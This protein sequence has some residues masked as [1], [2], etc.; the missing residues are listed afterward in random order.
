M[1][2]KKVI[3]GGN[4]ASWQGGVFCTPMSLAQVLV[5][6]QE[7]NCAHGV[8]LS[9]LHRQNS[10]RLDL[11]RRASPIANMRLTSKSASARKLTLVCLY[12]PN[13]VRRSNVSWPLQA[14]FELQVS[15]LLDSM[16]I[17]LD[18]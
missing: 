15:E 17:D 13:K 3:L 11:L 4:R 9:G 1:P 7:K 14:P 18:V 10:E 5:L 8:W 6:S 2:A 12:R 16:C